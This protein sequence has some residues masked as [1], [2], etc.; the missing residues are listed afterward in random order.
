L[1]P[2]VFRPP[3]KSCILVAIARDERQIYESIKYGIWSSFNNIAFDEYF[4]CGWD[5]VYGIVVLKYVI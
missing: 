1:N 2:K 3:E 5:A 4:Q